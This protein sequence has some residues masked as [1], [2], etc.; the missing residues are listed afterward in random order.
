MILTVTHKTVYKYSDFPVRS[1]QMIRLSP[2]NNSHQTV[3]SWDVKTP[4]AAF[5]TFDWFGNKN[6]CLAFDKSNIRH[7][8]I[9]I[10][11]KGEVITNALSSNQDAGTLPLGYYLNSTGLT[12]YSPAMD[13]IYNDFKSLTPALE[14][15]VLLDGFTRL[16]KQIL[17]AVPY[18]TGVTT[19]VTT[20]SMALE[21]AA[22]VCQ[23]HS[24]ILLS[25]AR[26]LGFPARYVSGYI[27]SSD[28]S[29]VASHAWVEIW[30]ANAWHSF[31]VSNQCYAGEAHIVLAY[32]LDYVDASPIRGSRVG[33]GDEEMETYTIV[34]V[35]Q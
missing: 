32:G 24:H 19:S 34:Q 28:T 1:V 2:Q 31:D 33:G 14:V 10:I 12:G 20:A 7:R 23:D 18:I 13:A 25:F 29:H 15:N 27:Y 17:T 21:M 5:T 6:L 16:S 22:G 26:K 8:E 9:E 30:F 4:I 3:V 35:N 11:A